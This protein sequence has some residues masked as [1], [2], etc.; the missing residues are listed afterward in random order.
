MKTILSLVAIGL[1][2]VAATGCIN[3][4]DDDDARTT[5]TTT[6]GTPAVSTTTTTVDD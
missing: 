4:E 3:V 6:L 5:R 1:Y 2:A